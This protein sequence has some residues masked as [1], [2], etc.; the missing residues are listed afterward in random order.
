MGEFRRAYL[1]I[2]AYRRRRNVTAADLADAAGIAV[3][4]V[5]EVE[6]GRLIPS[7]YVLG[8]IA[9]ALDM[10]VEELIRACSADMTHVFP[11]VRKRDG[12]RAIETTSRI[13]S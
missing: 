4:Y 2:Q 1:A 3:D 7:R 6:R 9:V 11:T 13:S 5:K 12:K 8:K 10:P